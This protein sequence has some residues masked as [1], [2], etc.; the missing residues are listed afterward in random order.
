MN[1]YAQSSIDAIGRVA[2]HKRSRCM[3]ELAASLALVCLKPN[4]RV[5]RS[6]FKGGI[7][8]FAAPSR[9]AVL[10]LATKWAATASLYGAISK[11]A[12]RLVAEL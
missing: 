9:K 11:E 3:A 2:E 1:S 5:R 10:R 12:E 4:R 6:S 8:R 7:N